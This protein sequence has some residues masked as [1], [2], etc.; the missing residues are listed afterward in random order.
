MKER[1]AIIAGFRSPMGKAGGVLKNLK[2]SDLGA[3]IAKEVILRS[4]INPKKLTSNYWKCCPTRRFGQYFT[5][6][7]LESWSS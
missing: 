4:K 5:H 7:C 2:A 3:K 1:I 6:N